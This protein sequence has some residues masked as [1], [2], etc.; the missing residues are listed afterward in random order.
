MAELGNYTPV[1]SSAKKELLELIHVV[2]HCC[3]SVHQ[4]GHQ[5]A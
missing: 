4:K 1:I 5:D 2:R 3:N